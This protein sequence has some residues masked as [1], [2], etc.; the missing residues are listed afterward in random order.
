[1]V[2]RFPS[3]REKVA[4]LKVVPLFPDSFGNGATFSRY[5]PDLSCLPVISHVQCLNAYEYM[6]MLPAFGTLN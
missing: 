5:R 1:M 4:P 3:P 6:I 2:P